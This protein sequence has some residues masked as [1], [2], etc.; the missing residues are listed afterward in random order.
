VWKQRNIRGLELK[1]DVTVPYF[2]FFIRGTSDSDFAKDVETGKS[3]RCNTPFLCEAPVIQRSY[4]YAGDCCAVGHRSRSVCGDE[5]FARHV[6]HKKN[7]GVGIGIAFAI[8]LDFRSRQHT[9][10]Q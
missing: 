5:Q 10:D 6:V 9:R 2:E 7:W 3:V 8:A 4:Y 1:P